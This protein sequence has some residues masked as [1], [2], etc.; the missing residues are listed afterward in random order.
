MTPSLLLW[1]VLIP[2]KTSRGKVRDIFFSEKRTGNISKRR[3]LVN[4]SRP[5]IQTECCAIFLAENYWIRQKEEFTNPLPTNYVPDCSSPARKFIMHRK[6]SRR[7]FC[8][9]PGGLLNLG[10]IYHASENLREA[11]PGGFQTRGFPTSFWQRSRL[12]RGPFRDC[13]S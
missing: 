12:C 8:K 6:L 5:E 7:C 3:L 11:K 10:K 13:S 4:P 1:C 9:D 2:V